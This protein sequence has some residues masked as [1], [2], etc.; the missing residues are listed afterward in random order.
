MSESI[1]KDKK[2]DARVFVICDSETNVYLGICGSEDSAK[3]AVKE[4]FPDR[5]VSIFLQV[6][7]RAKVLDDYTCEDTI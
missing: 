6:V 2:V 5:D 3:E 7:S 1:V 4:F